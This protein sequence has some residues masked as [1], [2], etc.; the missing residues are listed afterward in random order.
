[1]GTTYSI[2]TI[3]AALGSGAIVFSA[4]KYLIN[5]P[6]VELLEVHKDEEE[7]LFSVNSI[8]VNLRNNHIYTDFA[9][10]KLLKVQPN[11]GINKH[12]LL[13]NIFLEKKKSY[14]PSIRLTVRSTTDKG[15]HLQHQPI[16]P[17]SNSNKLTIS[18]LTTDT[19]GIYKCAL[20]LYFRPNY[21]FFFPVKSNWFEFDYEGEVPPGIIININTDKKGIFRKNKNKIKDQL[22]EFIK[23]N[24]SIRIIKNQTESRTFISSLNKKL[25]GDIFINYQL[26]DLT[27]NSITPYFFNDKFDN[28]KSLEKSPNKTH[29]EDFDSDIAI[30]EILLL[31][32]YSNSRKFKRYKAASE[33][34]NELLE[35]V[36]CFIYNY[37]KLELLAFTEDYNVLKRTIE[38]MDK[39]PLSRVERA[40]LHFLLVLYYANVK[41]T[42]GVLMEACKAILLADENEFM[43][44]KECYKGAKA[45]WLGN[46]GVPPPITTA[47]IKNVATEL[48]TKGRQYETVRKEFIQYRLNSKS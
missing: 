1:M 32:I 44:G 29:E 10:V 9:K 48:V 3:L 16:I 33:A 40:D 22:S 21:L 28:S 19:K 39:M 37:L 31:T 18:G 25:G 2:W 46:T 12:V 11:Q 36:D 47:E 42:F 30:Q 27:K 13:S 5:K 15:Q 24:L 4:L 43:N 35:K 6:K 41:K 23:S 14:V 38:E 45:I 8:A 34:I 26:S 7:F 17:H 20:R